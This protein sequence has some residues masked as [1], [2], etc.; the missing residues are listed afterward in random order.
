MNSA[1]VHWTAIKVARRYA[2]RNLRIAGVY[3]LVGAVFCVLSSQAAWPG[4]NENSGKLSAA[5]AGPDSGTRPIDL[6][7][8]KSS[9]KQLIREN[10]PMFNQVIDLRDRLIQEKNLDTTLRSETILAL[11]G[12][13]LGLS[14][15]ATSGTRLVDALATKREVS[16]TVLNEYIA[17]QRRAESALDVLHETLRGWDAEP[18]LRDDDDLRPL[19]QAARQYQEAQGRLTTATSSLVSELLRSPFRD[20]PIFN[21][22]YGFLDRDKYEEGGYGLYTYVLFT[23]PDSRNPSF[24]DALVKTTTHPGNTAF[25]EQK[26]LNIFYVPV[27]DQ[28]QALVMVRSQSAQLGTFGDSVGE[29]P[30]YDFALANGI[31]IRLCQSPAARDLDIC[32][33]EWQGPYLLTYGHPVSTLET[34]SAPYLLVD[35]SDVHEAAFPEY[36][37]AVKEQLLRPDF[38][39]RRKIETLRL[40]LLPIVLAAADLI[41]PISDGLA[42][43]AGILHTKL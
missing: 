29:D 1:L 22:V 18:S 9:V 12:A 30:I 36:I 16:L 4:G 21:S 6:A 33:Q 37:G 35:L 13:A 19:K 43:V 24:F 5:T 10:E 25:A 39:D 8:F 23:R 34:L 27:H 11:G 3:L 32:G 26:Y 28:I 2:L 41:D 20:G 31:L 7:R 15:L 38:T 14:D 40:R 17:A 42:H